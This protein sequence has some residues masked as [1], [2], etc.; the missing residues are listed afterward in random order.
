M[1]VRLPQNVN[2]TLALPPIPEWLQDFSLLHPRSNRCQWIASIQRVRAPIPHWT[3]DIQSSGYEGQ[4]P[5]TSV[6][7]EVL[8]MPRGCRLASSGMR[9]ADCAQN[10]DCVENGNLHID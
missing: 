9:R 3:K 2:A 7:A 10:M 1:Q 8:A 6:L 4:I 5:Q